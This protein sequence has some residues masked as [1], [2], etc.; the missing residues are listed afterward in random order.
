MLFD[1][2]MNKYIEF[3]KPQTIPK[4]KVTA[5]MLYDHMSNHSTLQWQNHQFHL[6]AQK[7]F[8]PLLLE[9]NYFPKAQYTVTTRPNRCAG[10]FCPTC[11]LR[12][13]ITMKTTCSC[14]NGPSI[15]TSH[16]HAFRIGRRTKSGGYTA[17]K[18]S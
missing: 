7:R 11:A 10:Q 2:K 3:L 17:R 5:R 13:R 18:I 16:H 4:R 6:I 8:P 1:Y 14:A 9:P 15:A 12:R